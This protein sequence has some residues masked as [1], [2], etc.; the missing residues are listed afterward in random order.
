MVWEFEKEDE[1][2]GGAGLGLLQ[3]GRSTSDG[4]VRVRTSGPCKKFDK[5]MVW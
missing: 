2:H 4:A 1:I 3:N 5:T